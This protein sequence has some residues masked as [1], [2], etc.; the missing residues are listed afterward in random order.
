[1]QTHINGSNCCIRYTLTFSCPATPSSSYFNAHIHTHAHQTINTCTAVHP[2]TH[3]RTH[4]SANRISMHLL[5]ACQ[6]PFRVTVLFHFS[7]PP[8]SASISR[9]KQVGS[10]PVCRRPSETGAQ[11][12]LPC[13]LS[14]VVDWPPCRGW[15]SVRACQKRPTV[16]WKGIKTLLCGPAVEWQAKKW[17]SASAGFL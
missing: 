13:L 3:K 17:D 15:C 16:D 4:I 12:A 11:A 10:L 5:C 8:T 14:W 2:Q 1:M 9:M 7:P 6:S